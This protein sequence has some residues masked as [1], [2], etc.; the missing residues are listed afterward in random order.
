MVI[1]LEKIMKRLVS[2]EKLVLKEDKLSISK[3]NN[4]LQTFFI[5]CAIF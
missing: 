4:W 1:I 3:Q 2:A 5:L